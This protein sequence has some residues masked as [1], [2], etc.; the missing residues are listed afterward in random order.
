MRVCDECKYYE[1]E[2]IKGRCKKYDEVVYCDDSVCEGFEPKWDDDDSPKMKLFRATV[3]LEQDG[4][5]VESDIYV[6]GKSD[7]DAVELLDEKLK[8]DNW[9]YYEITSIKEEKLEEEKV[10]GV[11][12]SM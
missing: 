4:E 5:I 7:T 9:L 11:V 6:V 3:I 2:G 12:L 8:K 10:L 1:P